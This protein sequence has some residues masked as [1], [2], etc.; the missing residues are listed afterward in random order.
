MDKI[1]SINPALEKFKKVAKKSI[2]SWLQ[3]IILRN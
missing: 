1:F 3:K 2:L